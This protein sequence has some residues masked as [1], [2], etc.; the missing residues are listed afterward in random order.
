LLQ[1]LYTQKS[2]SGVFIKSGLK[3]IYLPD[4]FDTETATAEEFTALLSS[5][6]MKK[7]K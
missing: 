1:L 5:E 7:K 2:K 4:N 6:T 3:R